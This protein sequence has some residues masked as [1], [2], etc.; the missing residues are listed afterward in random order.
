MNKFA[1]ILT[2][3]SNKLVAFN[4]D[5]NKGNTKELQIEIEGILKKNESEIPQ[6][7]ILTNSPNY[8]VNI[9]F[10]GLMSHFL[11]PSILYSN[12]FRI[13]ILNDL[14]NYL[15]TDFSNESLSIF[16]SKKIFS[17]IGVKRGGFRP[18]ILEILRFYLQNYDK[19]LE[20]SIDKY[21]PLLTS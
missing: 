1:E 6:N 11:F 10:N 14:K 18:G 19:T 3:V 8:G 7:F 2:E 21:V 15:K 17:T 16:L 12:N 9:E 5:M 13:Q 20:N 4:D